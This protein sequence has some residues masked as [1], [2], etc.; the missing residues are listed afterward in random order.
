MT[1]KTIW[2]SLS[3]EQVFSKLKSTDKGLS[4]SEVSS[5]LRKYGANA[6][7]QA[8][9]KSA[10]SIF[11]S[12]FKS[13]LVVLLIVAVLISL[14]IG[15]TIDAVVIGIIV[16][17]NAILGFIQEYR[18]EKAME[19]LKKLSAPQAI[20][21]RDG[22]EQKIDAKHL[23]PGDIIILSEGDRIPAAAKL[24]EAYSLQTDESALTGESTPV[25]KQVGVVAQKC[26]VAD[27]K[28]MVF[29]NTIITR[30]RGK[31]VVVA[32]GMHT[33]IGHVAKMIQTAEEKETPL[34]RKLEAVGKSIGIA[35]IIIAVAIFGLGLW[36]GGEIFDMLMT[37][38]ALAVAAVPEGLPAIVTITLALGLSR[39]AKAK[40]L[41]RKLP[42][43]ETL[44]AT[45]VICSDKTG[46][47]TKNQMTVEKIY[48]NNK[49]ISITGTGYNPIGNF[50][51]GKKKII[52]T[53]DKALNLLLTIGVLC[54][55]AKL[56]KN[57]KWV[58][59][60]D[61]TEGALIV[62]AEKAGLK[63]NILL[64][65]YKHIGEIPFDSVRKL[66]TICYISPTRKKIAYVKGAPEILLSK[67][68]HIFKQGKVSKLT[69]QDKKNI[70]DANINMAKSALRVLGMAYRV[71]PIKINKFD[72]KL[73][74]NQLVFVGLQGMIDPP[75]DEVKLAIETCRKAGIRSVMITGDYEVTAT[76]IAKEL[77]ILGAK[78]EVI[79]GADL[80]KLNQ[81][82]FMKQLENI[83][84]YAR[85][86]PEHK[87]RI[88]KAWQ[89]KG[90]VVA[91][92]GDGV[93]D[94]PALKNA[95]IGIAMGISG[96]DVAKE[97]S[98]MV[99]QDDNFATIVRAVEEG[100]GIY[101]NIKNFIRYL[102]SSNV[103]EVMVIF[104]ASLL[105]L[106]LPLIA[107]QLLWMN[108]LTDGVPALA[109]GIDPPEQGIMNRPPRDPSESTI[110]KNMWIFIFLV[111]IVMMVG[112][113]GM[114]AK[115]LV[116][117]IEHARTMA[118]TTIV[119]FQMWNVFNSR[120]QHSIFNKSFWNNKWLIISVSSSIILQLV[121]VYVP[122][123]HNIFGT[124]FLSVIDWVWILV[125][126]LSIVAAVE[127][128]KFVKSNV[129][130]KGLKATS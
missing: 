107:V 42:A 28:N 16:I 30:G 21:I 115:F 88:L 119:M 123:F 70:L 104:A 105:G 106:P 127:L 45:T 130:A 34:Q 17:A 37:A 64:K 86:S 69:A 12:Q 47:L 80:D 108:L 128:Y 46:T 102:L 14:F 48:A 44:G 29:M 71:L 65:K 78:G 87:V 122:F 89:S 52:A 74:E 24:L 66:M 109:L 67:C 63:K 92:T 84:V 85:V 79:T 90:A 50:L 19:A 49:F 94:A 112:T 6:L 3:R 62:S 43:V 56:V 13:I 1:E 9:R 82:A 4:S 33:E 35:V 2:H 40:S 61:P 8:K 11:A 93:N 55:T 41:I 129:L 58:V 57:R 32:T 27:R 103:G 99:L 23:V 96:T 111:G 110:N 26:A 95:D 75:R 53:K 116:N 15:E 73:I 5:R 72:A 20:I 117:G 100:R 38:I 10:F 81:K 59:F 114:F 18:A 68:T 31:A 98:A 125:I 97:A 101:D 39:M 22:K 121:V 25:E 91:M 124:T 60:G 51:S 118:F 54:N 7:Q 83:S 120:T 76:A 36:R 126:S 77:G 113:V